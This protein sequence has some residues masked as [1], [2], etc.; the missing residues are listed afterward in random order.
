MLRKQIFRLILDKFAT[1]HVLSAIVS[2]LM[3][4]IIEGEGFTAAEKE[5]GASANDLGIWNN[6]PVFDARSVVA[7]QQF[8]SNKMKIST[9]PVFLNFHPIYI[10]YVDFVKDAGK[11]I[12][13]E[14]ITLLTNLS[15]NPKARSCGRVSEG[16]K[17]VLTGSTNSFEDLSDL[18]YALNWQYWDFQR[19]IKWPSRVWWRKTKSLFSSLSLLRM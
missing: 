16:Q 14:E 11:R 9:S 15:S 18:I 6:S 17:L 2:H 8:Y 1:E 12:I 10:T 5:I 7:C 4:K 19:S 13:L 3:T